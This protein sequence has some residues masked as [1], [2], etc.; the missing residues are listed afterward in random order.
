[1]IKKIACFAACCLATWSA[2]AYGDLFIS[3]DGSGGIEAQTGSAGPGKT[4]SLFLSQ[5]TG[6]SDLFFGNTGDFDFAAGTITGTAI[7]STEAGVDNGFLGEGNLAT[8]TAAIAAS[9]TSFNFN[10]EYSNGAQGIPVD[11]D[12]ALW[13]T[14]DLDTTG[15]ADGRYAIDL[16]SDASGNFLDQNANV[17]GSNSSLFFIVDSAAVPE[18][19]ALLFVVATSMLGTVRRR[20]FIA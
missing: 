2:N 16:R 18:P 20:R 14:V 13:L 10:Q 17:V 11:P 5:T 7:G 1:M 12:S 4:I 19:T 15:L 6:S 3:I 8:S 9:A